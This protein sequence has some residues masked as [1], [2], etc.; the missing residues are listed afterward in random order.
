MIK[1]KETKEILNE[2]HKF[3]NKNRLNESQGAATRQKPQPSKRAQELLKKLE[4]TFGAGPFYNYSRFDNH[5]D[6]EMIA[7]YGN[8]PEGIQVQYQEILDFVNSTGEIEIS[9]MSLSDFVIAD[10][11][12]F[13]DSGI[14]SSNLRI[15]KSGLA[16]LPSGEYAEFGYVELNDGERIPV[17]Y[18]ASHGHTI[19]KFIPTEY[20]SQAKQASSWYGKL[21]VGGKGK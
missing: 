12:Q 8:G 13:Q 20:D 18:S 14:R 7:D 6:D 19:Y 9:D 10:D 21:K 17:V 1:T 5:S 3:T 15:V 11:D 2:W 4:S 16:N